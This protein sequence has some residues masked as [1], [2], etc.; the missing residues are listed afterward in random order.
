[1]NSRKKCFPIL[2]LIFFWSSN[3]I[4]AQKEKESQSVS[5][6]ISFLLNDH[7]TPQYL[8]FRKTTEYGIVN[9]FKPG[10]GL[11]FN[12]QITEYLNITFALNGSFTDT[13][14]ANQILQEKRLLIDFNTSINAYLVSD[15]KIVRPYLSAGF[16]VTNFQSKTSGIV[17]LGVGADLK[18]SKEVFFRIQGQYLTPAFSDFIPRITWGVGI[19]GVISKN[20]KPK[21]AVGIEKIISK[22]STSLKDKD[23]DGIPDDQ[24]E[25]PEI[26]GIIALNGCPDLDGDGIADKYDDCPS[27]FGIEKYNGCPIPDRDKDGVNDEE[28]YCPDIPGHKNNNGCPVLQQKIKSDSNSV[29]NANSITH[30][31]ITPFEI[32]EIIDAL[33]KKIH[34]KTGSAMLEENSFYALDSL[35]KI[36]NELDDF[37]ITIEGHA[38]NSGSAAAN[39]ILSNDRAKAVRR[40]FI[41]KGI[42]GLRLESK[43]FGDTQPIDSNQTEEG[44]RNNRRVIFRINSTKDK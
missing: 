35:V 12:K 10:I 5:I 30:K 41:D 37:S 21:Q 1:M 9:N 4:F 26:A 18:I 40:Y 14:Y 8:Q 43:G 29:T 20:A 42:L 3:S 15:K 16:G 24:D 23:R 28:D 32:S 17:P 39:L 34:F 6:G 11:N 25:C 7:G 33:A 22:T 13:A 36:I 38:D 31:S 44:R 27:V 2:I 19:F